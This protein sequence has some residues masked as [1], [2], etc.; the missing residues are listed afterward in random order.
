M[1]ASGFE[2]DHSANETEEQQQHVLSFCLASEAHTE[3]DH[4][5]IAEPP[6]GPPSEQQESVT[7][8]IT[9]HAPL[10]SAGSRPRQ[11][12]GEA[13][14]DKQQHEAVVHGLQSA[15]A[16]ALVAAASAG[17]G[18]KD[19]STNSDDIPDQHTCEQA[20]TPAPAMLTSEQ[21]AGIQ[22][23]P[24]VPPEASNSMAT[25]CDRLPATEAVLVHQ[26]ATQPGLV[27]EGLPSM[28]GSLHSPGQEACIDTSQQA[29]SASLS[30][31]TGPS[32][33]EM[34]HTQ[35]DQE[36]SRGVQKAVYPP[37]G[38]GPDPQ[39]LAEDISRADDTPTAHVTS[40]ADD[41]PMADGTPGADH[42]PK[43]DD[44]SMADDMLQE[45]GASVAT[46][47][48]IVDDT[49]VTDG[50]A[51]AGHT[52]GVDDTSMADDTLLPGDTSMPGLAASSSNA[53]TPSTQGHHTH[54]ATA[55]LQA[56]PLQAGPLQAGPLQAGPLQE[57][58]ADMQ[59]HQQPD[60]GTA[61]TEQR[62]ASSQLEH[63]AGLLPSAMRDGE[64]A[65]E[66]AQHTTEG[67]LMSMSEMP[68]D[69]T[70]VPDSEEPDGDVPEVVAGQLQ[71]AGDDAL[72][73]AANM[74]D[75]AVCI[76]DGDIQ[77][78]P[79]P[80]QQHGDIEDLNPTS[81]VRAAD[82]GGYTSTSALHVQGNSTMLL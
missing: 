28:Q 49:P 5:V 35:A 72:L 64:L 29:D 61:N 82:V 2:T 39:Q 62:T 43:A 20:E 76:P 48:P 68:G 1:Q 54:I 7:L 57:Q 23:A 44:T 41:T 21:L 71:H 30:I 27:Q 45:D 67:L 10:A 16:L 80:Q 15:E 3:A 46:V 60:D 37:Q 4:P 32:Q 34:H 52:P 11:E 77:A 55:P 47:N 73:D 70:I 66:I 31:A 50:T 78:L 79:S 25:A 38:E 75:E 12:Q 58:E 56:G 13:A 9:A 26:D 40:S 6:H 51:M 65:A 69:S 24:E 8:A 17:Y 59:P 42:T 81:R 63:Q 74:D 22:P 36:M 14:A 18:V 53:V 33:H 19:A